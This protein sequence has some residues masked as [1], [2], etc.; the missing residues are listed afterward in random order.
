MIVDRLENW[1]ARFSGSIWCRVFAAL[2][3]LTPQTPEGE[4]LIEGEDL[5]MRVMS[6]TT[7]TP[8]EGVVEAHRQYIDVQM[9]LA[10]AE[11]IDWFP[12]AGL[13]TTD[14]YRKDQD[15]VH[16]KRPGPAPAHADINPGT[17]CILFPEDAHMPQV[18]TGEIANLVKKVVIKVRSNLVGK[19]E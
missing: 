7:R 19:Q 14:M 11:R 4:T 3:S 17:F 16:F 6:Y 5:I 12:I 15:V 10:G 8:E 9:A 1:Q 18:M 2:E 13:E